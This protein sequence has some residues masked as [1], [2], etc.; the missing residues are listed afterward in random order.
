MVELEQPSATSP[1][2]A[3]V[4]GALSLVTDIA[5]S[6][7]SRPDKM[8]LEAQLAELAALGLTLE[9]GV[10]VDDLLYFLGRKEYEEEPYKHLMGVFG[11]E[12]ESRPGQPVCRVV[13]FLDEEY[14]YESDTYVGI[15]N[16]LAH[17]SG[18]T[19]RL[20]KVESELNLEEETGFLELTL[21]G[22]RHRRQVVV[23]NDWLDTRVLGYIMALLGS[24]DRR[25]YSLPDGG[26]GVL[27]FYVNDDT[28][29][30]INRL[31]DYTLEPVV[32][33]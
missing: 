26:Q 6:V 14:V 33:R 17:M 9:P 5:A 8:K 31:M 16:R 11:T 1:R 30:A 24:E 4:L 23:D 12:L 27:L 22:K 20:T 21:D 10:T 2:L 3:D 15:V 18:S 19:D 28:A 13:W 29:G 25:F 7:P 32:T